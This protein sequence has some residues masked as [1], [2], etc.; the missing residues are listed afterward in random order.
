VLVCGAGFWLHSLAVLFGALFLLGLHSTL[1]GPVKYAI[2]P[3]HLKSEELVGGNALIE[4]GTFVAI[5]LGTLLGGLLAGSR[6][7]HRCGSPPVAWPS[8]SA[9][10]SPRA[11]IPV[12]VPPAPDFAISANP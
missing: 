3:Q 7:R 6:R 4:A 2:L 12:A 11:A 10:T 1:F 5:L 8:P 9:A